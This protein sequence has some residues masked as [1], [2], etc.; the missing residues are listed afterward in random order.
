MTPVVILAAGSGT[1]LGPLGALYD[2]A[3]LPVGLDTLMARH[4]R[5]FAALGARRFVVVVSDASSRT[6]A[7][8]RRLAD[9]GGL[10]LEILVQAERKGIGHAVLLTEPHVSG[11]PFVVVLGDTFYLP[12]D[13]GAAIDDIEGGV[14]DALLS[15]RPVEDEALIRKECTVELDPEGWVRRIV[16][17]PVKV[18]SRFKPCGVYFFGPALIEALHATPASALRGELELTDSIQTL[19]ARGGRVGV[20]HTIA[21]DVN[22]TWP[23]DLLEA[24]RACLQAEGRTK[25]VH[26]EARVAAG[27]ALD[28][29]V[30]S[31]GCVVG[32]G[33]RLERVVLFPDAV[34]A[35]GTVLA[36][37][38]VAPGVGVVPCTGGPT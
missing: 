38:L 20:R 23:A 35:P 2:K 18:L 31:R 19:V 3:L 7:E 34:V 12:R 13:L 22:V 25:M 1:R 5:A 33:S 27:A 16:E 29:A 24:N 17:K 32:T 21:L 26:A 4:F 15:V 37:A 6:A 11:G 9:E 10:S 30:V 28:Q 14:C 8:A 36:D